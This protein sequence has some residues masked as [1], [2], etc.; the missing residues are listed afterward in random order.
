MLAS[1]PG[2]QLAFRV[3]KLTPVSTARDGG[4]FFRVEAAL[5]DPPGQLQ[6]GM[7]G[8]GKIAIGEANLFWLWTRDLIDWIR[9][10]LWTWWR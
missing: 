7:E 5:L 6:P 10:R 9:L 8:V 3:S 2:E 4:N 1:M